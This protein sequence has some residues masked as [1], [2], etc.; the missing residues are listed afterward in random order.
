M[1]DAVYGT[2]IDGRGT[3]SV[4]EPAEFP[5]SQ[6]Q[7]EIFMRT[8]KLLAPFSAVA[9]LAL[10]GCATKGDIES[11]RSEIQGVR[12]VA[13]SADQKA[14][15]ASADAAKA[16]ADAAKAAQ[17]AQMASEK[18]DRIFRQGLRK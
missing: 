10:A 6:L 9:L 1:P 13:E 11:L 17:D 16:S 3:P 14:S 15:Q 8:L 12:A 5:R 4:P 7:K 18:S 2:A